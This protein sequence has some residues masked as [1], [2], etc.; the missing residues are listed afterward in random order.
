MH[1]S[2]RSTERKMHH[3]AWLFALARCLKAIRPDMRRSPKQYFHRSL[4]ALCCVGL[5]VIIMAISDS[6]QRRLQA[7]RSKGC[8]DLATKPVGLGN[9]GRQRE[10]LKFS[11]FLQGAIATATPQSA[12]SPS[13]RVQ[14][15]PHRVLAPAA[16][17]V[18]CLRPIRRGAWPANA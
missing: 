18:N 7:S 11:L 6:A 8:S 17:G 16:V 1:S 2:L 4:R 12:Q 13:P 9:I 10:M 3:Y 14:N 15:R 5:R